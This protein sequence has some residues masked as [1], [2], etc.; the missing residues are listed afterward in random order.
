MGRVC[1]GTLAVD[2]EF[3]PWISLR[4]LWETGTMK[5]KATNVLDETWE[6]VQGD[7][8]TLLV[9]GRERTIKASF[10]GSSDN[11][12]MTRARL[13]ALAPEMY[14][15]LRHIATEICG[16]HRVDFDEVEALLA[17]AEGKET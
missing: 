8:D 12:R 3:P 11:E 1:E 13:A 4:V 6:A 10:F 14:R 16:H 7:G 15:M 2:A 5:D 17:R 9:V